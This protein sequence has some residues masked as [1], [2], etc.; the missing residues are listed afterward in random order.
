MGKRSKREALTGGMFTELKKEIGLPGNIIIRYLDAGYSEGIY[1]QLE[2]GVLPASDNLC[3]LLIRVFHINPDWLTYA[4]KP[5]LLDGLRKKD[6]DTKIRKRLKEAGVLEEGGRGEKQITLR[7]INSVCNSGTLGLEWILFGD[8][9]NREYPCN[10]Q[11]I[12]IL[13]KRQ[14]L[15]E[16][17]WKKMERT[18]DAENEIE[19]LYKAVFT[20]SRKFSSKEKEE[21]SVASRIRFIQGF[22]VE[23]A[24]QFARRTAL[25]KTFYAQR[26]TQLNN[27]SNTSIHLIAENIGIGEEWIRSGN[28]QNCF[29]PCDSEMI[30]FLKEN[31]KV[32]RKIYD[33]IYTDATKTKSGQM[34]S[35]AKKF[36]EIRQALG[37]SALDI[38]A[39]MDCGF[40]RYMYQNIEEGKGIPLNSFLEPLIALFHVEPMFVYHGTGPVLKDTDRV[41]ASQEDIY[42]R[43]DQINKQN[44]TEYR[45]GRKKYPQGFPGY[46][47]YALEMNVGLEFVLCGDKQTK[48]YPLDENMVNFLRKNEELRKLI[49]KKMGMESRFYDKNLLQ[50]I[51]CVSERVEAVR[52]LLGMNHSEFGD[53]TGIDRKS[54]RNIRNTEERTMGKILNQIALTTDIDVQYLISGD[55]ECAL[56]PY[57]WRMRAYLLKNPGL[58]EKIRNLNKGKY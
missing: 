54:L 15:R 46:V 26:D 35:W 53:L 51:G 12:D 34:A 50:N 16:M 27:C 41:R 43:I 14:D 9:R 52:S 20:R 29:Y 17:I 47:K 31:P 55:I 19:S 5:I 40:T 8:E 1:S 4:E 44:G 42:E 45:A 23:N 30:F 38:V 58:R 56:Y 33:A 7:F 10:V 28:M 48:D 36:C 6:S 24:E 18:A 13:K 11:M 3:R 32:R 37:W 25:S 49:R 2:A 22:F 57:D 39:Y 21:D